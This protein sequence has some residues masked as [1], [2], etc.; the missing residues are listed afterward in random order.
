[1]DCLHAAA[2]FTWEACDADAAPFKPTDVLL[3]PDP[4]VIGSEVTFTIKGNADRDVAAGAISMSVAFTGVPIYEASDDLCAKTACPIAPGPLEIKYVQQLPPIA[5]PGDYDVTLRTKDAAGSELQCVTVHFTMVPA[6]S[7][8]AAAA[9]AA[10]AA[11]PAAARQEE[12]LVAPS[13]RKL[14]FVGDFNEL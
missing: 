6:P 7:A 14:L 3:S 10:A 2:G 4:P 12:E 1:M 8:A 5:P 13:R 9:P 11:A